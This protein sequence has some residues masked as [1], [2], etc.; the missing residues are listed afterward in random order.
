M[1]A[2][3]ILIP[4]IVL[5]AVL[6]VVV[7]N[8]RTKIKSAPAP[9]AMH[10]LVPPTPSYPGTMNVPPAAPTAVQSSGV[11]ETA[12]QNR[13]S[14]LLV[15]ELGV[16]DRL[17]P[18]DN[19]GSRHQRFIVRLGSGHTVLIAHNIDLAPRVASLNAGEVVEFQGEYEWSDKGGVVHW[20]HHDPQGKHPGGYIS[21]KGNVFR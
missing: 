7:G 11:I 16:V 12:F 18:D 3:R 8:K 15:R 6:P 5:A 21:H 17:L 2:L 19:D 4:L 14:N 13:Q 10:S 20:T 9:A 1:K